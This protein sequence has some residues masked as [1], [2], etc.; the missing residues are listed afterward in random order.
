MIDFNNYTGK[1]IIYHLVSPN[2]K[3]YVGQ[4]VNLKQRFN[5]YS[6]ANCKGQPKIYNAIL[7][8]GFDSF[9]IE[10]LESFDKTENYID[11]LNKLEIFYIAKFNS[12]DCGLNLTGGGD[13]A[14]NLSKESRKKQAESLKRFYQTEEGIETR[15]KMS[16][17]KLAF[18][19]TAAGRAS[20]K[21]GTAK[22]R[23][24]VKEFFQTEKG[25]KVKENRNSKIKETFSKKTEA[26]KQEI[27]NKIS[28]SNTGKKL[29]EA[30][31]QKMSESKKRYLETEE[32]KAYLDYQVETKGKKINMY[33]K[34]MCF[35]QEFRSMCEASRLL[36][37]PK[38]TLSK[39]LKGNKSKLPYIF[40]YKE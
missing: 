7:K 9:T 18:N 33:D 34:D 12:V 8:Y 40:K 32:G 27:R 16:E 22:Q 31:V 24:L 3:S 19:E 2:G 37:I 21:R 14:S 35:M 5:K 11:K 28:I 26:E 17:Q 20:L 1:A 13:G 36:G 29:S 30:S 4:T 10:I 39:N 25:I 6:N 15:N 38:S 23:V